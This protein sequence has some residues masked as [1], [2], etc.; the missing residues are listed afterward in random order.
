MK[1]FVLI[2]F[3][4]IFINAEAQTS[5]CVK[6]VQWGNIDVCLPE[7]SGMAECFDNPKVK[8]KVDESEFSG[9]TILGV[10]LPE[11][12]YNS[13]D[14]ITELSLP[15]YFKIY[16]VNKMKDRV[17]NESDL[18][19]IDE[20]V[21][22]LFT[23]ENWEILKSKLSEKKHGLQIGKPVIIDKYR[24]NDRS[25]SYILITRV[26][27]ENGNEQTIAMAMDLML[28]KERVVWLGY[29]IRYTGEETIKEIKDKNDNIVMK[30]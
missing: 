1:F 8:A 4:L 27:D 5:D 11:N 12:L 28:V 10:Y 18:N 21:Q 29:Y 25:L 13:L 26:M 20:S 6:T 15:E 3:I 17:V 2:F 24:L 22:S 30:F 16:V 19:E 14:T 9:N 23:A 7:V